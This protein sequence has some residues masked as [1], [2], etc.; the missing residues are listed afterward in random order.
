[1]ASLRLSQGVV[2]FNISLGFIGER[3]CLRGIEGWRRE[4]FA[5]NEPMQ[6]VQHMRLGRNARLQRHVDGRQDCLLVVLQD[7]R[8]D[9]DHLPIAPRLL[10]QVLLQGPE[11]IGKL[12]ERCAVTKSTRLTL[13]HR[14]IVTPVVDGLTRPIMRPI[15]DA[16][17]LT[18]DLAFCGDHDTIWVDPEAHRSIGEVCWKAVAMRSRCTRQVGVTRFVYSTN[19]SNGLESAMRAGTS[20]AQ[21]SAMVPRI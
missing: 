2:S 19:P 6:Q 21:M 3:Q 9:I 4:G 5:V 8:Q 15:Y 14:Q 20:S 7:E 10:E 12:D 13:H 1:M 18:N 16:A 11:C 17:V